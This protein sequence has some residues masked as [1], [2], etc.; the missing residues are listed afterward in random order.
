MYWLSTL[1]SQSKDKIKGFKSVSTF[2]KLR[3]R[4]VFNSFS[5]AIPPDYLKLCTPER[6]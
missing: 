6:V 4:D 1:F 2:Y 3:Y 5:L